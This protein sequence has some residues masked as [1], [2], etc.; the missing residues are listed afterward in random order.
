[1]NTVTVSYNT[2]QTFSDVTMNYIFNEQVKAN[3][4]LFSFLKMKAE[5]FSENFSVMIV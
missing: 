3:S 1:M 5:T 4:L 2:S